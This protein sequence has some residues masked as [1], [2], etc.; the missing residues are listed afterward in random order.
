MTT[1]A[2]NE[3]QRIRE[4]VADWLKAVHARDVD[5]VMKDYAPDFIGYD[6]F[7]PTKVT[8]AADYRKNYQMWFDHCSGPPTYE[9]RELDV[10]AGEDVAFCRSLNRMATPKDGGGTEECWLRVTV[11]FK[12]I[13]GSWK[14]V[15]EHVSV[16]L[17]ME[18][19]K[20]VF[21]FRP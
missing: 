4:L 19:Q 2:Q 11:C 1:L 20:G 17:D 5:A 16:P 3:E 14:V 21:D 8:G 12:K 18:T 9:I 13:A 15:H 10:T 6:L 7:A